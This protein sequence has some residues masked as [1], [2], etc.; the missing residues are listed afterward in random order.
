M[1]HDIAGSQAWLSRLWH[2]IALATKAGVVSENN[3][4]LE[5]AYV[6]TTSAPYVG[7]WERNDAY[8]G[9]RTTMSCDTTGTL[10]YEF[11]DIDGTTPTAGSTPTSIFPVNGL[12]YPTP[13]INSYRGAV[14]NIRWFRV[15]FVPD[16]DNATVFRLNAY[17]EAPQNASFPLDQPLL[18]DQDSTVVRAVAEGQTPDGGYQKVG[19]RAAG[20]GQF[21]S[22]TKDVTLDNSKSIFGSLTTESP[23]PVIRVDF[24]SDALNSVFRI[25]TGAGSSSISS[26]QAHIAT[27]AS[28]SSSA[29]IRTRIPVR[30]RPG[31]EMR[32]DFTAVFSAP[33]VGSNQYIGALHSANQDGLYIGFEDATFYT[34]R[35]SGGVEY[36][37]PQSAWNGDPLD[38]SPNSEYR[39]DGVPEAWN[40]LVGNVYRIR[41]GWL[42]YSVIAW[43]V[44]TPDGDYIPLHVEHYPNTSTVPSLQNTDLDI[45]AH[46]ANTSNTSDIVLNTASWRG[47]ILGAAQNQARII[48]QRSDSKDGTLPSGAVPTISSTLNT[49]SNLYDSGWIST[50]EFPGGNFV[51]I[52]ADCSLKVYLLNA[53]T[54]QGANMVGDGAPAIETVAFV[55]APFQAPYF[56]EYYR[57]IVVNDSGS[58]CTSYTFHNRGYESSQQQLSLGLEQTLLSFFPA[59]LTRSVLAGKAPSGQYVNVAVDATGALLTGSGS[60]FERLLQR[61]PIPGE[62]MKLDVEPTSANHYVAF[63]LDGAPDSDPNHS[64]IRIELSATRNPVSIRFRTGVQWDQRTL[65]W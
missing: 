57:I 48:F 33:V 62:Q 65:G 37:T 11:Y 54:S 15:R 25:N 18:P 29:E 59:L 22:L 10:F 35:K 14:K 55:P 23:I 27:G 12:S 53:S 9:V 5:G 49:E 24:S 17:F 47:A 4:S 32:F 64:V 36:K 21:A 43:E 31:S 50:R 13:N 45:W 52:F 39:R 8:L 44:Q 51:N 6:P 19:V 26:S 30:Y 42:G 41:L 60:E 7:E 38:G 3:T 61:R 16:D 58:D 56:D 46:V 63:C 20:R 34:V 28:P 1:S 40:P 2:T